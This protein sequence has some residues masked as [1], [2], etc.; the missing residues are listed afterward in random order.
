VTGLA[1]VLQPQAE[2]AER[3]AGVPLQREWALALAEPAVTLD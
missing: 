3:L 2:P 1:L